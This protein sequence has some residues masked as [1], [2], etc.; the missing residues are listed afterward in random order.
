MAQ[1]LLSYI[2]F[3]YLEW[4]SRLVSPTTTIDVAF[5]MPGS[6]VLPRLFVLPTAIVSC[7][8]ISVA[9]FGEVAS[10]FGLLGRVEALSLLF[11]RFFDLRN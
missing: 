4:C 11:F 8:T 1:R 9:V 2:K 7:S 6:L 3:P 10:L 5:L